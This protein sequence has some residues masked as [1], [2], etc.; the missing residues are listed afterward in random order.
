MLLPFKEAGLKFNGDIGVQCISITLKT[1][2]ITLSDET[3][4][5]IP[6]I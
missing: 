6:D 5:F 3:F 2:K 4:I 1:K